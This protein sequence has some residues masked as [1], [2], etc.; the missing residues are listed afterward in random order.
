MP[1]KI[2]T[3]GEYMVVVCSTLACFSNE[4]TGISAT[5]LKSKL[6]PLPALEEGL[7][8]PLLD[9]LQSLYQ[10]VEINGLRGIKVKLIPKRSRR[11]LW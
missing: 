1:S 8:S 11:L 7:F 2:N 10:N 3:C 9:I 6:A 4:Y 5:L